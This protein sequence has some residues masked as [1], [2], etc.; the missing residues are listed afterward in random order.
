[1]SNWYAQ[2]LPVLESALNSEAGSTFHNMALKQLERCASREDGVN[3]LFDNAVLLDRLLQTFLNEE[4]IGGYETVNRT[5]ISA[6]KHFPGRMMDF[7]VSDSKSGQ[8]LAQQL[9]S[10]SE[11][12]RIRLL[13]LF[14]HLSTISES[15]FEALENKG[16]I[17]KIFLEIDNEDLLARLSAFQLL[18]KV[19]SSLKGLEVMKIQ[20]VPQKLQSMLD[21]EISGLNGI[22]LSNAITLIGEISSFNDTAYHY[23]IGEHPTMIPALH[24]HIEHDNDEVVQSVIFALARICCTEPGLQK[25]LEDQHNLVVRDWLEYGHSSNAEMKA[26]TFYSL[27]IILDRHASSPSALQLCHR[28]YTK[29][30]FTDY[31]SVEVLNKNLT[32]GL[33]E[34]KYAALTLLRSTLRFDWGL[35]E[36]IRFPGLSDWML[37]R[38]SENTKKGHELKFEV[39]Q[40][41]IQHP[42]AKTLLGITNYHVFLEFV[43]LGV[44]YQRAEAAV[45]IKDEHG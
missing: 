23:L 5:F 6:S 34:L 16:Y 13:D 25:M 1:M 38:G 36:F 37:N 30:G 32:G 43:K 21:I 24:A 20:S 44:Y 27:A 18:G 45:M 39:L 15:W 2:T 26:T 28:L 7:L 8:L 19:C 12:V 41:A 35:E 31:P 14:A 33:A 10:A 4:E 17:S 22:V 9:S 29:L 11:T 42:N 3:F 40:Q